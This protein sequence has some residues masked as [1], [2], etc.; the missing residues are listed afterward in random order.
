MQ[1]KTDLTLL[2]VKENLQKKDALKN[3]KRRAKD[4]KKKPEELI[5]FKR[6][7][8]MTPN[9]ELAKIFITDT[10]EVE[11]L[12]HEL[13]IYKDRAYTRQLSADSPNIKGK[14]PADGSKST[15][16]Y[17]ITELSKIVTEEE[18]QE[19]LNMYED[20]CE[21]EELLEELAYASQIRVVRGVNMEI[22]GGTLF[23]VVNEA[24][25]GYH[26]IL[27]T[28]YDMKNSNEHVIEIKG[29]ND[30]I[31]ENKERNE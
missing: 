22:K 12:A 20:G 5:K 18:K 30:L 27:K 16:G 19:L 6:L 28:L 9:G 31:A 14:N 8:P 26:N 23:R 25:D 10:E 4:I 29:L 17:L 11:R 2:Q 21:P 24:I 1:K 7:Y 13:Q 15:P 3:G